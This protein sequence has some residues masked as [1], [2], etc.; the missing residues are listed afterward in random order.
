VSKPTHENLKIRHKCSKCDLRDKNFF[1]SVSSGS[2]NTFESLKITNE[3]SKGSTLFSQ[4]QPSVGVY[5]LC[6]G[7]VK[8]T[9]WSKDGRSTILGIVEAGEVLGLSGVISD[10]VH[11]AT[12]Q[13]IEDCQINF[14]AKRDFQ[15]FL[16][17]NPE[18]AINAV[19]Q[20]SREQAAAWDQIRSL[21]LS[22]SAAERLARLLLGWSNKNGNGSAK[23]LMK[24]TF[25]HEE[26]ASM[27][28]TSR[29]TVTRILRDFKE[30]DLIEINGKEFGMLDEKQL[31]SMT[32]DK[33]ES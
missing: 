33:K 28:G 15:R 30:R 17:H 1:C 5:V 23:K 6:Q 7:R 18:A 22:H 32:G 21:A 27:I 26:M 10:V 24:A 25:T 31:E 14:V 16:K 20:L 2:L 4:G 29:E 9:A 19:R 13:A 11:Q 12:A 8:L 3:Y